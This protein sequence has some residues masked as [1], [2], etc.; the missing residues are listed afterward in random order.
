MIRLAFASALLGLA[1]FA[2]PASAATPPG[3]HAAA[4]QPE[5][6]TAWV[7][8]RRSHV[9]QHFRKGRH[10]RSHTRRRR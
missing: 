5:I 6:A 7:K 8:Y 10:V 9:R 2:S 3:V 4:G 1:A